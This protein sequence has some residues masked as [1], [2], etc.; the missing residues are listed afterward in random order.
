MTSACGLCG[1]ASLAALEANRCPAL[2]PYS[3]TFPATILHSLPAALRMR[4][5]IF[6][7]TGGL[8]AAALFDAEGR[9]EVLHEDVGRHNAVDKLI[10]SALLRGKTPLENSMVLVSGRASYELVQKCLMGGVPLLAA[11]G[12]PSVW[13]YPLRRR[14]A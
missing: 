7:D 1:K 3:T 10:G 14:P 4:Q 13:L 12:A 6:E 5:S 8:H 2:P 9:L 11:V